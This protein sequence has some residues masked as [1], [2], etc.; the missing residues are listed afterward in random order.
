MSKKTLSRLAKL[1]AD[2]KVIAILHAT[3]EKDGL[4]SREI[5][6]RVK[7]PTSQLYYT[8]KKMQDENLLQIVQKKTIN[9]LQEFYY[10]SYLLT[11]QKQMNTD[12]DALTISDDWVFKNQERVIQLIL[13]QNQQFM[14]SLEQSIR[15]GN[16]KMATSSYTSSTLMLT[17][18]E[19]K[20]LMT[21]IGE[22]LKTTRA[23]ATSSEKR[24]SVNLIVEKWNDAP[25]NQ[26][27]DKPKN[28]K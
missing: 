27:D 19:E 10:S 8:L 9:N 20:Q 4:P 2:D 25:K 17:D 15:S 7:I 12:E 13:Y 1:L 26:K 3:S 23:S 28:Q 11:H 14:A 16:E 18:D 21:K 22:L 5:S 24:H 6:K